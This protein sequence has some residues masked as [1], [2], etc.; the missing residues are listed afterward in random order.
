[1]YS[2]HD[3]LVYL[4]VLRKRTAPHFLRSALKR[5]GY[6]RKAATPLQQKPNLCPRTLSEDPPAWSPM[7]TKMWVR[8][9]ADAHALR[10]RG[11]DGASVATISRSEDERPSPTCVLAKSK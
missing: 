10:E 2:R 1:M 6:I 3:C 4:F 9:W 8:T 5:L 7:P 11:D